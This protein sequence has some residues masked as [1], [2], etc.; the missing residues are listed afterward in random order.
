MAKQVQAA[1]DAFKAFVSMS[2]PNGHAQPGAPAPG[3]QQQQSMIPHG[4]PRPGLPMP[5]QPQVVPAPAPPPSAPAAS[6]AVAPSATPIQKK[7]TPKPPAENSAPTPSASAATP[8]ASAPTPTHIVSSPQTPKSPR[9]KPTPK[10]KQPPKPR[11]VSV[12]APP[13]TPSAP[14]AA[15]AASP[16]AG[17]SE[18][19]PPATPATPA[20][21]PTPDASAGTKRQREEEPAAA[22]TSAA[23]QPAAKKIKTEWDEPPSDI[24]AKR[25]A[26]ADAVKTEDEAVKFFEQMSSWLNQEGEESLKSE[27][28]DSLQ[29][30]LKA[31]PD[32]P[33]DGG[34][35]SLAG[36]SFFDS[37]TVGSS[38]PKMGNAT[39]DPSDFFDFTSYGLTDEDSPSKVGTP[40]L[41]QTSSSVGPSPGS[42]SETEAHPPASSSTADTAKIADPKAESSEAIPQDLWRAIDGGEAAYYNASDN[43]SWD[44]PM[45]T[46]EHPWQIYPS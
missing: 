11:K 10:P 37:I 6:P 35:S 44:K 32:V 40:D 17:P 28:A 38:S 19:K 33:D 12:K 29:E 36:S 15:T 13:A 7:P 42:A 30:I 26:Q 27:I 23:A 46:V 18:T 41:V 39:V 43:W 2:M 9:N 24:L 34:L 8:A 3:Q 25:Q 22:S 16:A 14:S 31:Y 1:A 4:Q 45:P 5:Q 20:S 21:A